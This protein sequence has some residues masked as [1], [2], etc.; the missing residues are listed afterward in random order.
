MT[1]YRRADRKNSFTV[2]DNLVINDPSLS[3]RAL[4]LLIY[5][6]SKPDGWRVDSRDLAKTHSEGRD[7]IRAALNELQDEGY[8]TQTR[9]RVGDKWLI[10]TAVSEV[11]QE[12]NTGN[13][14]DLS[15]VPGFPA[16]G[17]PGTVVSTG[18][19]YCIGSSSKNP[20]PYERRQPK[21]KPAGRTLQLVGEK[22]EEDGP[23][24]GK[25]ADG[26]EDEVKPDIPAVSAR[27]PRSSAARRPAL[28]ARR[29]SSK[30]TAAA[31]AADT[32]YRCALRFKELEIMKGKIAPANLKQFS[33]TLKTW[34]A[35]GLELDVMREMVDLFAKRPDSYSTGKQ[36][37]PWQAFINARSKL[38]SDALKIS[39][40]SN[41]AARFGQGA[42]RAAAR[43]TGN[44]PM[45]SKFGQGAARAAKRAGL[46]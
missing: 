9:V 24:L 34:Y 39:A 33:A 3:F 15:P 40:A 36:A 42:A 38:Q 44:D 14:E 29:D 10:E 46:L 12:S 1:T 32:P 27:Q 11:K 43:A 17:K 21:T 26:Y 7:A 30:L 8:M 20:A 45:V 23:Q 4:G 28:P 25:D 31:E 37:I 19:K 18:S 22:I 5:I 35:D 13:I 2:T 41:P 6:L 16:A